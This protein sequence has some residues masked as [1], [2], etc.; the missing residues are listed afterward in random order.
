M[1]IEQ[2]GSKNKAK[3]PKRLRHSSYLGQDSHRIQTLFLTLWDRS[4]YKP[5]PEDNCLLSEWSDCTKRFLQ[6]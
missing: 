5:N 3:A 4:K 6:K 2:F 1:L